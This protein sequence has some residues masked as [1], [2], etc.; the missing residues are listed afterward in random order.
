MTQ[1]ESIN[2]LKDLIQRH[3]VCYEVWPENLVVNGQLVKV[4]FDLELE[5]THEHPGSEVLPGCLHC[6]EVYQ[7]LQRIAAWIMPTEERPT[8]YE[9]QPFD[10]AIHYA[11]KRKMRS[12][13]SLNIKIIHRHGFDQPVDDCEQMCLKE[14]RRKLAELGVKEGAWKDEAQ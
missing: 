11:P 14:M 12:E 8:T 7:D 6:Q 4:G 3:K 13:V 10:R 5:G 2:Q 1:E 9:I